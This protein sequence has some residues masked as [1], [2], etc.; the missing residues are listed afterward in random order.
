MTKPK[1]S[2]LEQY[3]DAEYEAHVASIKAD[4]LQAQAEGL[5]QRVRVQKQRQREQ[6]AKA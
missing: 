6:L 5:A 4:Y 3:L 2:L 1:R